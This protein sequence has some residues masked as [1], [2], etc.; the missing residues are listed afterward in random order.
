MDK[1]KEKYTMSITNDG[2]WREGSLWRIVGRDTIEVGPRIGLFFWPPNGLWIM[3]VIASDQTTSLSTGS[4][5]VDWG[6]VLFN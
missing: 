1:T 2:I 5:V 6:L 3:A 4:T